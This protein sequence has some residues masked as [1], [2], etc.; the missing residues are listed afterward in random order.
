M[1]A[2]TLERAITD[3]VLLGEF[4]TGSPEWHAARDQGIGGSDIA[5]VLGMMTWQGA[6]P[7]GVWEDKTG[8]GRP[9]DLTWPLFRG[10][11]DEPK[12]R[13]WFTLKTGIDVELTGTWMHREHEWMRVNPDGLTSDGGG[14]EC[15]SHSWRMGEEWTDEQVSDAAELQSQWGM[16]VTGLPHWWVIA[17]LGDDEP[18]IRKVL[19]DEGLI[20]TLIEVAGKFWHEHVLT[21]IAPAVSG[22]DV[23]ALKI[24]WSDTTPAA[25]P[26]SADDYEPLIAEL[27]QAKADIKAAEARKDLAEARLRMLAGPAEVVEVGGVKRL[28][29]V[30]NGTWSP[31]RFIADHP[32]LAAKYQTPKVVLDVDRIKAD[33]PTLY[34]AY[35]ARVLRTHTPKAK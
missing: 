10:H 26:G 12:L 17:Q 27:E 35:R 30:P 19:R 32:D 20:A 28:S 22:L 7:Y 24:R 2:A 16:A 15:K 3:A 33:H 21:D 11:A 9:L 14:I 29:L 23:D 25:V 6:T 4:P 1:S 31:T 8:R 34:A 5:K 18:V 13:A